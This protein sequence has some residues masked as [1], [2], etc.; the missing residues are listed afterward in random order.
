[1]RRLS[2]K[3]WAMIALFGIVSCT[4]KPTDKSEIKVKAENTDIQMPQEKEVPKYNDRSFFF[5]KGEVKEVTFS[6]TYAKRLLEDPELEGMFKNMEGVKIEFNPFGLI[7]RMS[8]EGTPYTYTLDTPDEKGNFVAKG[9]PQ[10][11]DR[12]YYYVP[13]HGNRYVSTE[14]CQLAIYLDQLMNGE[15]VGSDGTGCEA[16]YEEN[17]KIKKLYISLFSKLGPMTDGIG[18]NDLFEYTDTSEEFP[19]LTYRGVAWGGDDF[20]FDYHIQ[21]PEKDPQGNWTKAIYTNTENG[22]VELTITRVLT[23][24]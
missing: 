10:L 2:T 8:W 14:K 18:T 16:I 15:V 22:S 5:L 13:T 21:Y 4:S 3:V 17:G 9:D 1:M 12:Y 24:Y 20:R 19:T 6:F 23:Y 7:S 11:K